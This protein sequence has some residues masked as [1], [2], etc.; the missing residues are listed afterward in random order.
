MISQCPLFT[1]ENIFL[2]GTDKLAISRTDHLKIKS[3]AI[4]IK[5]EVTEKY[6]LNKEIVKI[7]VNSN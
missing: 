4:N 3:E 6:D 5:N 7:K 1:A 2:D